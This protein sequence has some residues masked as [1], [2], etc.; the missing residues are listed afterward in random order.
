MRQS[1][2]L[3]LLLLGSPILPA[4]C[5]TFGAPA[6]RLREKWGMMRIGD[7]VLVDQSEILVG[8][9]LDFLYYGQAQMFPHYLHFK[10]RGCAAEKDRLQTVAI[11]PSLLPAADVLAAM[12]YGWLFR[13]PAA[14]DYTRFSSVGSPAWLPVEKDSVRTRAERRHLKELLQYAVSGISY[15]QALAFCRWRTAVDSIRSCDHSLEDSMASCYIFSLLPPELYDRLDQLHDS[16]TT[17][18]NCTGPVFNFLNAGA[19]CYPD[20]QTD[21]SRCGHSALNGFA[22][23]PSAEGLYNIQGNVAEMTTKK[24]V[25]KGG[26]YAQ[27]AVVALKKQATAYS[28]SEAWLGFRCVARRRKK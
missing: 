27:P 24:G 10:T 16:L 5:I 6:D 20:K 18:K 25:A 21:P 2:I 11:D 15:E 14:F 28:R 4:Q 26:S 7:S 12:P 3:F 1:F 23:K 17:Q 22:F 9:Y 19:P 8:E 13:R